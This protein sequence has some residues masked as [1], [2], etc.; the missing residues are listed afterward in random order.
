MQADEVIKNKEWN[1]LSNS[2]RELIYEIAPDEEQFNF[3]KNILIASAE[4]IFDVPQIKKKE[5]KIIPV[6]KFFYI[7]AASV[8]AIIF[9]SIII[10]KDSFKT[11]RD[12]LAVN[13]SEVNKGDIT[14]ND[15]ALTETEVHQNLPEKIS[16][17]K[18]KSSSNKKLK[19]LKDNKNVSSSEVIN[20][21]STRIKEETSYDISQNFSVKSNPA[22][23]EFITEIY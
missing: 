4:D 22:L 11:K 19:I 14:L 9:Y 7:A 23:S 3:V 20:M 18:K 8:I 1:E 15:S 21:S 2:E 16:S 17:V 13:K 10:N 12:S 5:S 6:R